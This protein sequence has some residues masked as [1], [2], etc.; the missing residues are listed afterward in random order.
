MEF[1]KIHHINISMFLFQLP[2]KTATPND[3]ENVTSLLYE[4][5]KESPSWS[6]IYYVEEEH[7]QS[8]TL[9]E[10]SPPLLFNS[11]MTSSLGNDCPRPPERD[12]I[13]LVDLTRSVLY[14]LKVDN[15]RL[16]LLYLSRLITVYLNRLIIDV[17]STRIGQIILF[18]LSFVKYKMKKPNIR[19]CRKQTIDII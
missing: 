10:E 13:V 9:A 18:I 5:K 3:N 16:I 15:D 11:L 7:K 1:V 17:V 14:F 19:L 8:S 4:K 12:V 6:S 2:H